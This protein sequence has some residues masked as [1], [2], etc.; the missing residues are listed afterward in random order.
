MIDAFLA[1]KIKILSTHNWGAVQYMVYRINGKKVKD[2]P[3]RQCV[4][5]LEHESYNRLDI[6]PCAGSVSKRLAAV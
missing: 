5:C 2:I 3:Y 4:N 1:G 6:K